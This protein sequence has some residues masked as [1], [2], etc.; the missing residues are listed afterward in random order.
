MKILIL[1][2]I[3]IYSTHLSAQKITGVVLDRFSNNPIENVN[4]YFENSK[5]GTKTDKKGHFKINLTIKTSGYKSLIFSH[6]SYH[7]K[8]ILFNKNLKTDTIF[9]DQ[10]NRILTEVQLVENK[11]LK[12][13]IKFE[14]L[15]FLPKQL[16]SF[17]SLLIDKKIYVFGGDLTF[18][19]DVYRKALNDFDY[20]IDQDN[21][22][23]YFNNNILL[24]SQ[25]TFQD[26][27]NE[28][29]I[30]DIKTNQWNNED[31]GL[32][33]RAYHNV[34]YNKN[35]QEI[36]ILGGKSLSKNRN[37]EYLDNKIEI[38]DLVTKS[39][40]I[41][42]TNPHQAINFESFI[43][44]NN[45]IVMGGSI[46]MK[47]NKEKVY[48]NKI[49]L[50]DL[51]KGLWYHMGNMP[52]AK[53]TNGI[54]IGDKIFFFGGNNKGPLT[55]IESFDLISGKWSVEGNLFT[56]VSRPALTKIGDM[57]YIFE[58]G[59]ICTYNTMNKSLK[60]YHISLFLKASKMYLMNNKLFILG[61][62]YQDEFSLTPSKGLFSID[63][64][65]FE[66]SRIHKMS[67]F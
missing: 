35:N 25:P 21:A 49:H 32:R 30:Y 23:Q 24:S 4:V 48:S 60:E 11:K 39:I 36:Y 46:K 16:H 63:L 59:N 61:G 47:K 6:I 37:F 20:D 44:K 8:T 43:Y 17:A 45:L 12:N 9:L 41:D 58:N 55:Q 57:I 42:K 67:K 28:L 26:F 65:Q 34:N 33:K 14:K 66:N 7:V 19:V 1:L 52:E 3:L 27:N 29:L 2:F 15:T 10:K 38:V 56:G 54:L 18:K 13:Y 53:E 40:K 5:I 22:F 50:F 51:K 31:I 62:F 64:H